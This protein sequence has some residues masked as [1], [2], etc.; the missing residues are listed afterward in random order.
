MSRLKR[1][2]PFHWMILRHHPELD[3][4]S[5]LF[6]FD[7]KPF[8]KKNISSILN[9]YELFPLWSEWCYYP[10]AGP[11]VHPQTKWN[12]PMAGI[13]EWWHPFQLPPSTEPLVPGTAQKIQQKPLWPPNQKTA[14]GPNGKLC[15]AAHWW[16]KDGTG[17]HHSFHR[18]IQGDT[19]RGRNSSDTLLKEIGTEK[20]YCPLLRTDGKRCCNRGGEAGAEGSVAFSQAHRTNKLI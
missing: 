8:S 14:T 18:G 6:F 13:G 1:K 17:N 10:D 16:Q 20:F 7:K 5:G 4:L 15:L 11:G 19:T 9:S 2:A 3:R 12:C